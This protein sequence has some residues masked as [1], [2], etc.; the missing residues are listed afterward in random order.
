MTKTLVLAGFLGITMIFASSCEKENDGT[1]TKISSHGSTESHNAGQNC[2]TCHKSGG[3]G[4]GWFN[5][6]GTVYQNSLTSIY[7]NATVRLY[8][9]P[10]GTGTLKYTMQVDNYGNFYTTE[11]I[12]FSTDLYPSVTGNSTPKYMNSKITT[13]QCSSCHGASEDKLWA[14]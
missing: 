13:G 4:E 6:A 9:G 14:N 1:E 7:P 5:L 8:T 3:E 12:D 11:N 2:M 10:D